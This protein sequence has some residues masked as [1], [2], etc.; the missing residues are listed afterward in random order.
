MTAW[1]I[2]VVA[3]AEKDCCQNFPSKE[4]VV[5]SAPTLPEAL[6]ALDVFIASYCD[7]LAS[8]V[9]VKEVIDAKQLGPYVVDAHGKAVSA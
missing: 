1:L 5:V 2:N 6:K 7:G 4:T 9:S 8:G 3:D